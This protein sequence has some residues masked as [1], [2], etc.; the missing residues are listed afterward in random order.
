MAKD[1]A[2]KPAD[3]SAPE[4]LTEAMQQIAA[5]AIAAGK[6]HTSGAELQAVAKERFPDLADKP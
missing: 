5:E 4:T 6:P 1:K 2:P 3:G